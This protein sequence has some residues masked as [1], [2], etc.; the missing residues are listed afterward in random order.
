MLPANGRTSDERVLS[1]GG[2]RVHIRYARQ[3]GLD[4]GGDGTAQGGDELVHRAAVLRWVFRLL[5]PG[6]L[7]PRL[8]LLR[9]HF[10]HCH[11][12]EM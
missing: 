11:E 6:L 2:R 8:P 9:L 10:L 5:F 4:D 1:V 12:M 3:H 7:F